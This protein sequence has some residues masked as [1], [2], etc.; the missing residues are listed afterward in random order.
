MGGGGEGEGGY[1]VGG[2]VV[3]GDGVG[4]LVFGVQGFVYLE[5]VGVGD[6]VEG[7]GVG[8]VWV[9]VRGGGFGDEGCVVAFF[10]V[11][12]EGAVHVGG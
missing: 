7:G 12:Y 8:A 2:E 1:A 5:G 10:V 3:G 6:G 9:G 11:D 4:A